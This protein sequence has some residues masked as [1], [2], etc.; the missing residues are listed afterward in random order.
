[1]AKSF[2]D[3]LSPVQISDSGTPGQANDETAFQDWMREQ[4]KNRNYIGK[5]NKQKWWD[6]RNALKTRQTQA[7]SASGGAGSPNILSGTAAEQE[8]QIAGLNIANLG[9]GQGLKD[10]G[11]DVQRVKELQRQRTEGSDPVSEA[12]RNAKGGSMAAAQRQ[13][14]ASG[15]KGGVAAGALDEI[16]RKQDSEIAASLYGQQAKNIAA[17]RSLASN[18]L[19]G[20]TSL[21]QGSK[22][23]G[24]ARELPNAPSGGGLFGDSVICTELYK[25][26]HMDLDTYTKDSQYGRKLLQESPHVVAGYQFLAAPIVSLMQKS[27]LFTK[28]VSYPALKWA[29][30]IAN[31]ENSVVGYL[32]VNIGQPFCGFVGKLLINIFGAKYV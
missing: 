8:G 21:M 32:A 28:I 27:T 6:Q 31:E 3:T 11:S 7:E 20:T 9:Y 4:K 18:M 2:A 1:M 24:T 22:A 14:A 23:E 25:Q 10:V 5:E 30:H 15:V 29:R 19:S 13:M 26:G 12:I 16:A 17:E